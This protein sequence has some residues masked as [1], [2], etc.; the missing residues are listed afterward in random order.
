MDEEVLKA[1]RERLRPMSYI[2][3]SCIIQK[4]GRLE[5][6]IFVTDGL[7]NIES[8]GDANL[9]ENEIGSNAYAWL[10]TGDFYGEELLDWVNHM[11]FPTL[12]PLSTIT[13]RAISNVEVLV[14][15]ADDLSSVVSMFSSHF[16]E[17]DFP[18][19]EDA[20]LRLGLDK[21]TNFRSALRIK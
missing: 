8:S 20:L 6:M 15:T 19:P 7:V 5:M 13:A 18:Y 9:P 10:K 14:L 17:L 11:T 2:E 4:D 3:N 21:M 1:I 12:L 16:S